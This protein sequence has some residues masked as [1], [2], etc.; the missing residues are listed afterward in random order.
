M[1][2]NELRKE[3]YRVYGPPGT[4]KTTWISDQAARAVEK[5]GPDQVSICSLTN[6][7]VREVVGRHIHI[8]RDNLSTLHARC[9]RSLSAPAPAETMMSKFATECPSYAVEG[10]VPLSLLRG[11]KSVDG[12]EEDSSLNEIVMTG[13][14]EPTLYERAQILRQQ[15]VPHADWPSDVLRWYNVW[16]DWC[17]RTGV[18]D[19][20]GWL[21][22]ALRVRP[23]PA[24]QV[25]FV[26]EAQDHTPLQ[27]EVIRSWNANI[28]I[29]VG[30]DD[31]NLY[32]WSGAIPE[33]FLGTTLAEDH[34]IVLSQSYRVP[35]AVHAEAMRWVTRLSCRKEKDYLPRDFE[36][37]VSRTPLSIR[38]AIDYGDL[39]EDLLGEDGK[40]YMLLT[41]CGYLLDGV[42]EALRDEGVA[43]HNPYR[44]GNAK[45]NPLSTTGPVLDAFLR[46]EMWTGTEAITW[47]RMLKGEVFRKSV[48]KERFLE[49]CLDR[50]E[51]QLDHADIRSSF[52]PGM[53]SM[54]EGRDLTLF[55]DYRKVGL[56]KPTWEYSL[57]VYSK[58]RD[59]WEP[60]V[61]VGT[62]HSVK[63]GQ[64]DQVY[65]Y[66]DLSPSGYF[67]YCGD[68]PDRVTRLF[69]VGMTR[70]R[71][72]LT[73]CD[74]SQQYAITW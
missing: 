4:G 46:D 6:S 55:R 63:G 32:E 14:R 15:L 7:A 21:E 62:I 34:E 26:D 54:L 53:L 16:S 60:R 58:P 51:N 5:F 25:I 10:C 72:G 61:I 19:F 35:R 37:S 13:S 71:E 12:N 24:Q 28:R 44:K 22:E 65:L 73:L 29:L 48:G 52:S 8:D 49:I 56:S 11:V 9:K 20:T 42:L 23:L 3:E 70:S 69:Y 31:Q 36:G 68:A 18:L 74:S 66:P 43:F 40:T 67:D 47:A 64:A 45:W 2:R 50:G 30:D 59:R 1:S 33:A 17:R 57:A 38:D 41:S 27:L 39:P